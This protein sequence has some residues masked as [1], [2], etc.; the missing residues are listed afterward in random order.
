MRTPIGQWEDVHEDLLLLDHRVIRR[1]VLHNQL[2]LRDE[3]GGRHRD[4]QYDSKNL[5]RRWKWRFVGVGKRRVDRNTENRRIVGTLSQFWRK[6]PDRGRWLGR[7]ALQYAEKCEEDRCLKDDGKTRG[8]RI[9]PG[10]LVDLHH[11]R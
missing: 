10:L 3:G 5:R 8:E 2:A 6:R 4:D 9:S 11:F 7:D 1:R